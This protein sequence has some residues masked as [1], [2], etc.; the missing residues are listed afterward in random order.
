MIKVGIL[1]A[2]GYSGNELLGIISR[3]A[4]AEVLFA[5]A[6]TSAGMA[7]RELYPGSD[8]DFKY[9][10][11]DIREINRAD[12]VFIALPKDEAA[13]VAPKIRVPLID[14]SPAHRFTEGY[15]Y[16]LPEVNAKLIKE[17]DRIANPGCYATACILGVLPIRDEARG[18]IAFDCKSGYSGGGRS[19]KYEHEDNLIPYSI[20]THYQKPEVAK[21]IGTDFSF[22]THV[23]GV[24]RGLIAT[25]H[26]SGGFSG[27]ERR[28][29]EFYKGK[30]FVK[31]EAPVP[32]FKRV[33]GSMY[34]VIGGIV[35]SEGH[36]VIVSAVDNLLKGAAS[37]A[38][39]NMNI[40]FGF[41]E[42]EGLADRY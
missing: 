28:Y 8:S 39:Q 21:F 37:Q 23:V 18:F 24:F 36:A 29:K 19:R 7:V 31:V 10:D 16:G 34:C 17:S 9:T 1:G 42:K 14:L 15:V 27:L 13:A 12:V 35:E 33:K 6:K 5:Q 32:D 11:P 38:V 30:P 4:K 3:H 41:D 26:V 20:D 40:R 25:I 2:S 22:A